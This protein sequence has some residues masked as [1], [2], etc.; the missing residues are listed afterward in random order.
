GSLGPAPAGAPNVLLLVLDTVRSA[1][2]GLYGYERATTPGLERW[3]RTGT[4]FERATAT[5]SWT[6]PSHAGLFTGRYVHEL[7]AGFRTPMG[8]RWPT[9]AGE[10]R[11]NGYNTAGFSANR[12][13]V[14]WEFGLNRGFDRFEDYA[15]TPGQVMVSSALS[16]MLVWQPWFQNLIGFHD[17]Y[18]RKGA[19]DIRV[20]FLQWISGR[21]DQGRP[22]FAFLNYYDAHNPYLPPSPWN[23][24]F[25]SDTVDYVPPTLGPWLSPEQ[26]AREQDAYEGAIAW[27]DH[28]ISTLLE[29]LEA[30]GL[31]DNTI[32]VITSDHG[33]QFGEHGLVD[34][35]NSLYQPLL[36]VPLILRFP[37]AVPAG[38]RFDTPV[39]LRDIP[40]TMLDLAGLDDSSIPGESLVRFWE[41]RSAAGDEPESPILSGLTWPNGEVAHSLRL[42]KHVYIEWFGNRNELYDL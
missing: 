38:A 16:R 8:S 12:K 37:G 3:A 41:T 36:D 33:E 32:L 19:D 10:F 20:E 9:V 23:G 25:T 2:L 31:L 24:R 18:G 15:V 42:D 17:L 4:V 40:V 1:S 7:A 39:T 27:L 5:S 22:F 26:I 14:T 13:Y 30:R 34:H 28:E 11:R 6:L 21:R 29:Q 35:G